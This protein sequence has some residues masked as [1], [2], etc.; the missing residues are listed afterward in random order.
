MN[1]ELQR[2]LKT[3]S[4]FDHFIRTTWTVTRGLRPALPASPSLRKLVT[5]KLL[6]GEAYTVADLLGLEEKIKA[7]RMNHDYRGLLLAAG[8]LLVSDA[9][10]AS[11]WLHT[12]VAILGLEGVATKSSFTSFDVLPPQKRTQ[13]NAALRALHTA[14]TCKANELT[15]AEICAV[16]AL[17]RFSLGQLQ[18]AQHDLLLALRHAPKFPLALELMQTSAMQKLRAI[19]VSTLGRN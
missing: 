3:T 13:L 10:S 6:G 5:P 12:G 4:D 14:S 7:C 16:R 9:H 11:G 15:M 1:P 17:T 8:Q 19:R 18:G 2:S